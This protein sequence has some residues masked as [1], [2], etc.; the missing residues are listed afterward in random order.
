M[1]GLPLNVLHIK[2]MQKC[3]GWKKIA[4]LIENKVTPL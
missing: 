4:F 3:G 2:D 1:T